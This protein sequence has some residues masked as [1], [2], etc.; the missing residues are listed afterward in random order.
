MTKRAWPHYTSNLTFWLLPLALPGFFLLSRWRHW[1][2]FW[3]GVLLRPR[4]EVS[5]YLVTFWPNAVYLRSVWEREGRLPQWRTLIFGGTP[6]VGDPQ[7]GLGYFPNGLHRLL[8]PEA[9][10]NLLLWLHLALGAWGALLLA[11]QAGLRRAGQSLAGVGFALFPLLYA[12]WGLG[13]VGLVYAAAYVPWGL[14]AA[15]ALAQGRWRWVGVLALALG[16][17]WVNHPQVALY[18]ALV[19]AGL[20]GVTALAQASA[21][22]P[23]GWRRRLG[24]AWAAWAGGGLWSLLVAAAVLFPLVRQMPWL[25]R[26]GMAPQEALISSLTWPQLLG[27]ALPDYGGYADGLLY[28]GVPLLALA[29]LGLARRQARGWGVLLLLALLYGLGAHFPPAAWVITHTPGLHSVRA[30]ARIWVVAFPLALLLAGAGLEDLLSQGRAHPGLRGLRIGIAALGASLAAFVLAFRF[31]FD[32]WPPLYWLAALGWTLLAGGMWG[33][34]VPQGRSAPWKVVLALGVVALDLGVM[35]AS[36]VEVRPLEVFFDR[37]HLTAFLVRQMEAQPPWRTY[38][39]SYSLPRHI[40]ARYAIETADG[41][42]PLYPAAYDA[43]MQRASGVPRGRY[44]VTVPSME[45]EG[46]LAFVNRDARPDPCLLGLLNVRYVL[47]AFPLRVEGLRFVGVMDRVW[48][49]ENRCWGPRAF[50]VGRVL[51]A[52]SAEEALQRLP[53]DAWTQRAVVEGARPLDS[54]PVHGQV[55]WVERSSDR[56]RLQVTTDRDAW[57]VLSQTWHPDWHATVDGVPAPY[58]RTDGALGGVF[59]PAG[60]HHIVLAFESPAYRWGRWVSAGAAL[61]A[62]ALTVGGCGKF[63][64]S[65]Q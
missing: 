48:V 33:G 2:G 18:T 51:P 64:K 19:G 16:A 36:L 4:A 47:A 52:A 5:D 29:G 24:A 65:L 34:V 3:Q 20:A 46:P 32:A 61:L 62:L 59:V 27:L 21:G 28:L 38:S 23:W 9:A 8:P 42:D 60:R 56:L 54:G 15:V 41:V 14:A 13:H 50:L 17:Q 63:R 30:P 57:L 39:P 7:S 49:Y 11:R 40:A 6:L 10:F 1:A 26:Q 22:Q 55:T 12:H 25:A 35:D 44:T 58:R 31:T 43:L 37:P 45:G 53:R